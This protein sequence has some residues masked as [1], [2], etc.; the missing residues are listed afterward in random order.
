MDARRYL[1]L[2]EA[3]VRDLTNRHVVTD[4]L[5]PAARRSAISRA[6]YAAFLVAL[7]FLDGIKVQVSQNPQSHVTVQHALNNSGDAALAAL[8]TKLGTLHS[9]RRAA[10]YDPG[11]PACEKVGHAE[12]L[13][14]LARQVVEALDQLSAGV[15]VTPFDPVAAKTTIL[16]WAK[17][18]GK[19]VQE[20][21]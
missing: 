15:S 2:A 17:L 12:L 7:E 8:G 18:T 3:L 11:K 9:E 1:E 19:S 16:A 14:T 5:E 4:A 20:K 21:P 6:Y 10:D 13:V